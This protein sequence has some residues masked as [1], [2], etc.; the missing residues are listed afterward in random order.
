MKKMVSILVIVLLVLVTFVLSA[1]VGN[2][3][4]SGNSSND[5][6]EEEDIEMLRS[7]ID[8]DD[9]TL[10]LERDGKFYS[11][12]GRVNAVEGI[13][14]TVGTSPVLDGS[15]KM[16]HHYF[17]AEDGKVGYCTLGDVPIITLKKDDV[18]S[19]YKSSPKSELS[20]LCLTKV[21]FTYALP[22]IY[23]KD[24]DMISLFNP[25]SDTDNGGS[26]VKNF[27]IEDEN[28]NEVKNY[29][30]LPKN[31]KYLVTA[32]IAGED[33]EYDLI[34]DSKYFTFGPKSY[35]NNKLV[36]D[37]KFE[38]KETEYGATYDITGV[39]PGLY[40]VYRENGIGFGV[41][42]IN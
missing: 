12:G 39:A 27:K 37:Y 22:I 17:I 18:I 34:S 24:L 6:Y 14:Y 29:L 2:G 10:Y 21:N 4:P 19:Y 1:C 13:D 26:G 31:H 35:V 3:V 38:P 23:V 41:I 30:D 5:K 16:Y 40:T 20:N 11:L 15:I 7:N 42:R 32:E 25:Y 8:T 36:P 33:K 28:G 9:S